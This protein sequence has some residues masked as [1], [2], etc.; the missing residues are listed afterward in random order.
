MTI[1]TL[2]MVTN[3][4]T[5]YQP[6]TQQVGYDMTVYSLSDITIQ[7]KQKYTIPLGISVQMNDNREAEQAPFMI[8]PA[9]ELLQKGLSYEQNPIYI[10][11]RANYCQPSVPIINDTSNPI[12]ISAFSPVGKLT[13]NTQFD[14]IIM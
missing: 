4:K 14:L 5:L 8:T 12:T 13:N 1:Y 6:R 11:N 9:I 7:S 10:Y 3:Y 2:F